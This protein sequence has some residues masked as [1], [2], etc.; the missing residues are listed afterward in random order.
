[1]RHTITLSLLVLLIIPATLW[2]EDQL[3]S[4]PMP[5]P[6]ISEWLSFVL[7]LPVGFGIS[8]QLPL[9]MLFLQRIGLITVEM[10]LSKWRIAILV[11]FVIRT[12]ARPWR[13]WPHPALAANSL[14]IVAVALALPYTP[15]GAWVGFVP[16]PL[17]MLL[18]WP[19]S[20]PSISQSPNRRTSG[21]SHGRRRESG[22]R[23]RGPHAG[24]RARRF[25]SS[26]P[27]G[28]RGPSTG[29]RRGGV[30]PP[31]YGS[32]RPEAAIR[33]ASGVPARRPGR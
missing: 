17:P 14:G 6:R 7:F 21:S 9:V 25:P 32:P 24:P 11:I 13:S 22:A 27:P 3:T 31:S 2:A 12:Q 28:G 4:I 26:Q 33:F 20:P 10:Y 8:F 1:M 5:D 19:R 15:L 16:P 29:V 23:R 30:S 18:R